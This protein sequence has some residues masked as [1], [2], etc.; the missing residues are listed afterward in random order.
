MSSRF[1]LEVLYRWKME[2]THLRTVKVINPEKV[3]SP[4]IIW[5]EIQ[6]LK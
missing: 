5:E 1:K 6:K 2:L 3:K 4:S